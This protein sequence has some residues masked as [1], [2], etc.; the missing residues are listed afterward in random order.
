MRVADLTHFHVAL[1]LLTAMLRGRGPVKLVAD[2]FRSQY[3]ALQEHPGQA[4]KLR[5]DNST[6]PV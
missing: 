5:V 6:A 1:F 2:R 4:I 3:S